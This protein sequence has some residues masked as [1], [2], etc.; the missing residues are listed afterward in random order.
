M[1]PTAKTRPVK[2][3]TFTGAFASKAKLVTERAPKA[4]LS[5]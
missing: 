4:G 1:A 3:D 2:L 5:F